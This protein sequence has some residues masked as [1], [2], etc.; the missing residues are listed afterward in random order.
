M[1]HL[2]PQK[3]S[4]IDLISELC[5]IQGNRF[6]VFEP[7]KKKSWKFLIFQHE[8]THASNDRVGEKE[9]FEENEITVIEIK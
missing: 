5:E 8:T 6:S 3:V 4:V 2:L 7:I 9:L 1:Y